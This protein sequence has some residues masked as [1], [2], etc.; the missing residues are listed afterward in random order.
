MHAC[1]HDLHTTCMIGA[2]AVLGGMRDLWEGRIL[3]VGQP[4]EETI[5][6]ADLMM[7]DRIYER[8]GR[9]DQAL[10]L[11]VDPFVTAGCVA[12]APGDTVQLQSFR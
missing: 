2:A 12:L 1:G 4:A 7:K 10:A 8:F 3:F 11:H 9:P 6:G 5:G